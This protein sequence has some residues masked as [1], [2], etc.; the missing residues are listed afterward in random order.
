MAT[1]TWRLAGNASRCRPRPAL[2]EGEA[3]RRLRFPLH[4][5]SG[6]LPSAPLTSEFKTTIEA[7]FSD[8]LHLIISSS[9]CLS[10]VSRHS[11]RLNP[12]FLISLGLT[13]ASALTRRRFCQFYYSCLQFPSCAFFFSVCSSSETTLLPCQDRSTTGTDDTRSSLQSAR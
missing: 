11:S 2:L 3:D 8:D 13:L 10:P 4:F 6:L 12:L 9:V 7:S 5:R 1:K